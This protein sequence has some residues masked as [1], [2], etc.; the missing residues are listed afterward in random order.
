MTY[1]MDLPGGQVRLRE[2]VLYIAQK[3]AEAEYFGL[4]KLN[5]ILWRADFEAY[6]DREMPVTGRAY[7]RLQ[8]G[9]APTEMRPLLSEMAD[10]GLID[11]EERPVNGELTEKRVRIKDQQPSLYFFSDDDIDYVDRAINYYWSKTGKETSD[12][13][14]GI[15][16]K[17]LSD[18]DPMP[19][20]FARLSD[21]LIPSTQLERLKSIG[22]EEGWRSQ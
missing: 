21:A 11:I 9:P 16:W 19:Y 14:H 6:A 4:T 2:L 20:E 17:I 13:S 7:Q 12:D 22:Q 5:K 18:L 10:S 15:A 3:C 1:R 8:F